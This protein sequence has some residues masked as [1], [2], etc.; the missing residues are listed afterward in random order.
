MT[1]MKQHRHPSR[2]FWHPIERVHAEDF[3]DE[4]CE[5]RTVEVEEKKKSLAEMSVTKEKFAEI[6][7]REIERITRLSCFEGKEY[8]SS[9]HISFDGWCLAW[10]SDACEYSYT[11]RDG[12]QDTEDLRVAI[13]GVYESPY[14]RDLLVWFNSGPSIDE[15]N[16][17]DEGPHER[18]W[19]YPDEDWDNRDIYYDLVELPGGGHIPAPF[20]N[21]DIVPRDKIPTSGIVR[22]WEYFK[23]SRCGDESFYKCHCFKEDEDEAE[24]LAEQERQTQKD[25]ELADICDRAAWDELFY[26]N[27]V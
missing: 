10:D 15:L 18:T 6:V 24:T 1:E 26:V 20:V 17:L 14:A 4:P 19:E 8:I 27:A 22:D 3:S 12:W 25:A 5:E 16:E 7:L 13:N 2:N 21:W 9:R 23:C 11:T